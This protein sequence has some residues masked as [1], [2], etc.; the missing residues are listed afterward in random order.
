MHLHLVPFAKAFRAYTADDSDAWF[1]IVNFIC[2]NGRVEPF[3]AR[4]KTLAVES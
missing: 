4:I 2:T 1:L 3:R